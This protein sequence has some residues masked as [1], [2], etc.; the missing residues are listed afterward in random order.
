MSTKPHVGI[1]GAGLSG[2]RCADILLQNGAR[3]T[4]LEARDRIGGRVHQEEVGGHLVDLGPNWIHG[5]G[6]NPIL[7]IANA[8]RTVT[9]DPEGR[10]IA[11]S[12]DGHLLGDDAVT[13]ASEFMW[14]TIEQAFEYSSQHGNIIPPERSLFD[15][16]QEK[17][18]QSDFSE[19]ERQLCLDSC[20]L[21]GAYVGDPIER[22]SLKFFC[23]EECIDGDNYFV[24]ST[25]KRILEY[26]S[27]VALSQAD[28]RFKQAVVSIDSLLRDNGRSRHQITVATATGERFAFDQVVVTCPMGWLKRN[29][30]A[31]SPALPNRLLEAVQSISYGRLEKVYI[32]FPRA[33][34]HT[35]SNPNTDDQHGSTSAKNPVFAQ[36]LE[37]CYADH[38]D[39]LE[40]N[41][42]CL[43][44]SVLPSPCNQPTLLFYTYGPCSTHIVEQIASLDPKST[45]Y[46][47]ILVDFFEPFYSRLPG[48]DASLPDCIPTAILATRWQKDPYAG[49]GSYCNFQI[50]LAQ[51]DKDI[52]V[53]RSGAG[54]GTERGLWFAGEHTAPFEALGTTTGAYLSGERA[55][56]QVCGSLGL[57]SAGVS[58]DSVLDQ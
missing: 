55:A 32:T 9:H 21:W 38:P 51:A 4:I 13:K 48:Y 20:K 53:L 46:R 58:G 5:T 37:P 10:N 19:E 41:Q 17:L 35:D 27:R 50:G 24:A 54:V 56:V 28:I 12:R 23:L 40:W 22:Q 31:F 15:F 52:E 33:F 6:T 1:I 49:N 43:S 34:W 16:F 47:Q 2:L 3:V 42:E 39:G 7:S 18:E 26:I 30:H 11:V 44:L 57:C 25:Y 8:T 45:E 36:F 29:T 14:A